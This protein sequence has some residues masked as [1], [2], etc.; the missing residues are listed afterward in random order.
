M[1]FK[2]E[3]ST[4]LHEHAILDSHPMWLGGRANPWRV[5]VD[6]S[7]S[8][9]EN[10]LRFLPSAA[11]VSL[12]PRLEGSGLRIVFRFMVDNSVPV[13]GFVG[14]GVANPWRVLVDTSYS[15]NENAL[16]FLPSAAEVKGVGVENNVLSFR[17]RV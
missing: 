17:F 12:R 5:L 7:Y 10:A 2:Y 6:T 11:E 8:I 3:P 16:R 4:R 15:I 14:W 9:N 13:S 1:S